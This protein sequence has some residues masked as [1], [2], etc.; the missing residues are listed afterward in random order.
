[1]VPNPDGDVAV[2]RTLTPLQVLSVA[3]VNNT[4][5]SVPSCAL[6][7]LVGAI[8]GT[9]LAETVPAVHVAGLVVSAENVVPAAKGWQVLLS[10]QSVVLLARKTSTDDEIATFVKIA[11]LVAINS[12][13]W[14]RTVVAAVLLSQVMARLGVPRTPV[15]QTLDPPRWRTNSPAS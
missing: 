14:L 3:G 13:V 2:T 11:L 8:L 12:M 4:V 6:K 5:C 9:G 15:G 1:M 10:G 7:L